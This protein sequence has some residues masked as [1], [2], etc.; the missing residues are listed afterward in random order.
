M[1]EVASGKEI[2]DPTRQLETLREQLRAISG[3]LSALARS[4]G[5]QPVLDEVVEAWQ[6]TQRRR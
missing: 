3:V 2:V 6:P 4:A 5:L 1:R